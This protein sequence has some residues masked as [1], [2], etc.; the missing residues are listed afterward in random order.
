[1]G[2]P[3]RGTSSPEGVKLPSGKK[4]FDS[5]EGRYV[6]ASKDRDGNIYFDR[7]TTPEVPHGKK[8]KFNRENAAHMKTLKDNRNTKMYE[9][10]YFSLPK[11]E[12]LSSTKAPKVTRMPAD[13]PAETPAPAAPVSQTPAAKPIEAPR[14]V[15]RV[16]LGHMSAEQ[17]RRR[18]NGL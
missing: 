11:G 4:L 12:K 5:G 3:K 1:M 9:G 6:G 13:K 10:G 16:P 17:I 14:Q 15:Q 8:I 18:N 7:D 2:R